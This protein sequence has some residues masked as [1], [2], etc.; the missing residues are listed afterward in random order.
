LS[1]LC[2]A[3]YYT[4]Q[5]LASY[6][7]IPHAI[8]N[9]GHVAG[10]G[11][12]PSNPH[13]ITG[14]WWSPKTGVR[15]LS[16]ASLPGGPLCLPGSCSQATMLNDKD[17]MTAVT[18]QGTNGNNCFVWPKPPSVHW[19][20]AGIYQFYGPATCTG[21][22]NKAYV[23]ATG[24]GGAITNW[25]PG[26]FYFTG[27]SSGE[28]PLGVHWAMAERG[29]NNNDTAIVYVDNPATGVPSLNYWTIAGGVGAYTSVQPTA[30]NSIS[31]LGLND[32]GAVLTG[33]AVPTLSTPLFVSD[34]AGSVLAVP[35]VNPPTQPFPSGVYSAYIN[36][37]GHVAGTQPSG[38][39]IWTPAM[40]TRNLALLFTKNRYVGIVTGLND[41]G[42][43]T[44]YTFSP[45]N[46]YQGYVL[47]P[48]MKVI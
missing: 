36:N 38:S 3:Q 16:L 19:L 22:N 13:Y 18:A 35:P 34:P 33:S 24:E 37:L 23:L 46:T 30:P 5:S 29:L 7:T 12:L 8:N 21:L 41:A 48:A 14:F 17:A 31:V 32:Q 11:Y 40:G 4:V 6:S 42:Q 28:L 2:C 9:H 39:F 27:A 45:P 20:P 44:T 1:A 10:G 43:I 15:S 47:S 25:M 26:D